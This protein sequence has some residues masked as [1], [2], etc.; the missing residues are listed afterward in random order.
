MA[1]KD[2]TGKELERR[3]AA[4]YRRAKA[5]KVEH[6][7]L[8]GGHQIDVYVEL[9]NP[10]GSV[11][12]IAVEARDRSNP[13]GIDEVTP[14]ALIVRHLREEKL[15]D[16][17]LIVSA[18]G[19]TKPGRDGADAS[20][21][22][23]LEIADL[24]A[25]AERAEKESPPQ[26]QKPAIPLPPEPY[27]AHPFLMSANWTGRER[28]KADLGKWLADPVTP[29]CCVVAHGGTGK[30]SLV[31]NWLECEVAPNQ[32]NL[33]LDGIFQWSFYEGELSFA[34]FLEDLS[35]YLGVPDRGDPVS[36]V[37]RRL[38]EG[39]FLLILDGFE[40]LL[41]EYAS[42]EPELRQ[43]LLAEDIPVGERRCVEL[44]TSRFVRSVAA[45][46]KSKVLLATRLIPEELN[47]RKGWL[48]MPLDG[49]AGEDAVR[50]LKA[51][52]IRGTDRQL[53]AAAEE[54][55]FHPL[56]LERLVNA[57][58]YDAENPDDVDQASRYDVSGDLRARQHHILERAYKTLPASLRRLLGG[59]SALRGRPTVGV[60]RFLEKDSAA[61][62]L[63]GVLKRLEEDLWVHYERDKGTLYLHP[64][65]RRY[66]YLQ[67]ADKEAVHARLVDYFRPLAEAVD[68]R[69]AESVADLAPVIEL[70]HQTV[71]AGLYDA[72]S[73]LFRVQLT[74]VLYFHFAAY[75]TAIQLLSALFPR[76]EDEA[77]P[78]TR[79]DDQS[80]AFNELGRCYALTGRS[81]SAVL[82]FGKSNGL[83]AEQGNAASL[84]NLTT[85]LRNLGRMHVNLGALRTA[86]A[87]VRESIK[88]SRDI[89][90]ALSEANGHQAL[91]MILDHEGD[92]SQAAM[93]AAAAIELPEFADDPQAL[94][95][96][97]CY[98]AIRAVL[99]GNPPTALSA[100]REALRFAEQAAEAIYPVKRD[101]VQ[102]HWLIGA[103]LTALA[104]QH[105]A[106]RRRRLNEAET[107]LTEALTR[108]RRINLV[109]LEAEILLS[110]AK[111]HRAKGD[112]RAA[113]DT[114]E[115]ALSIADR[116]E[117]RLNQADIHNFLA[118]LDLEA[119]NNKA[120]IAHARKAHERAWCDG[121]PHCY[122]PALDEAD[123]LLAQLGVAGTGP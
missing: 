41:C 47:G 62:E 37:L 66:A 34:R 30:S 67:L 114:A 50:L 70:Y 73:L 45:S 15:I 123:R 111:W 71:R 69:S 93:E 21:I 3:V 98:A 4:L 85:G 115:E 13:V 59:L 16:E 61:S 112:T 72:A 53:E 7:K 110:W 31:W 96:A 60:A 24:E 12:R 23:L 97:E 87:S 89:G 35:A 94:C 54:Y 33:G 8:L 27:F 18:T 10:H 57:L 2:K 80:W 120:A 91:S 118:L 40:R 49:L 32:A 106:V 46:S 99:M 119:G 68:T 1:E 78:L 86:E 100:S 79:K 55:G 117:Y 14:F 108:C 107:H 19:F 113:R 58:H 38:D 43:D 76:G 56:S 22:T 65:V 64:L 52:G 105:T 109:E 36:S 74:G 95:V 121:P 104:A 102:A 122:K 25:M 75:N 82:L 26:A 11:H 90:N 6:D 17:G 101:F 5:H 63:S 77:P 84:A 48:N 20:G 88:L 116:C 42:P 92:F 81:R 44:R 83:D 39:R 9:L 29:M 103:S 51:N 28:E